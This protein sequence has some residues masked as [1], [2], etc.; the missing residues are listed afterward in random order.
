MTGVL[1]DDESRYFGHGGAEQYI[2]PQTVRQL[3]KCA[4]TLLWGCSSGHL[5]EHGVFEASGTPWAYMMAGAYVTFQLILSSALF[6]HIA[7][8]TGCRRQSVGCDGQRYR[9][10]R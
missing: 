6:T 4:T 8:Q 3:A 10:I 5:A 9:Q 7:S 1:I 2:R